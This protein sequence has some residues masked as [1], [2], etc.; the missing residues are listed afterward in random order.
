[1]S[2]HMRYTRYASLA[3][4]LSLVLA[5]CWAAGESGQPG[6]QGAKKKGKPMRVGVVRARVADMTRDLQLTGEVRPTCSV[7]VAATKEGPIIYC[8]WREGDRVR[9]GEKLV[10][11]DR[12]VHQAEVRAAR[13]ALAVA[14]A[15]LADLR[16][17]S[18]PEEVA[19][20]EATVRKWRA[21]LEEARKAYQR[22]AQLVQQDFTS[23]QSV[24]QARERERVAQA[25]LESAEQIL[26]MLRAGPTETEIAVKKA[27]VEEASSRLALSEA[28]LSECTIS[29]PFDAVVT[30]VRVRRGDLAVP[31]TPLVELYAPDSLVVRFS[32]PERFSAALQNG[33]R[34]EA[35]LDALP[36][37]T[38][39]GEVV[40]VYPELD[41]DMRTRTLEAKLHTEAGLMP[42]QFVRLTLHLDTVDDAVTIPTDAV[43]DA[44]A[45][46][47]IAFVVAEGKALRRVVQTGIEQDG[48]VQVTDGLSA[49]E[50]VVVAGNGML[51]NG[52]PVRVGGKSGRSGVGFPSSE[53]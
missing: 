6:A 14:Q 41:S 35:M 43:L 9:A 11:I 49:G 32:V 48:I 12:E 52:A 39:P 33:M 24:D 30:G 31:R 46:T 51:K 47:R 17:G 22:Q 40:R 16:A 15:S 7:V 44:P 23:Q 13:A 34:L 50:M 3:I 26:R 38:F 5:A 25:E 53:F 2:K 10:E 4:A 19:R 8:P 29:A 27:A 42:Y 37:R 36:G 1:M 28:H 21:T 45:G 20:A 18:R